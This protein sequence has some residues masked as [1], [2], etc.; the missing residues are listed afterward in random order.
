MTAA[1]ALERTLAGI[2][3][4]R[5]LLADAGLTDEHVARLRERLLDP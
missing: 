4:V 1:E 3:D 2:G 5:A